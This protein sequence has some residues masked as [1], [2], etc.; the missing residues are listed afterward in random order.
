MN[1][2]KIFEILNLHITDLEEKIRFKDVEIDLLKDK[3]KRL[4][5]K[6]E[7]HEKKT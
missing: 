3:V 7:E 5:R 4:E 2:N 6:T 1:I